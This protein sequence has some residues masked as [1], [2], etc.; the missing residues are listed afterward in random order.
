MAWHNH[1]I[2]TL[3][4]A[5]KFGGKSIQECYLGSDIF[6]RK[7]TKI[8][9]NKVQQLE[10][11][12]GVAWKIKELLNFKIPKNQLKDLKGTTSCPSYT[13]CIYAALDETDRDGILNIG[14][15]SNTVRLEFRYPQTEFFSKDEIENKYGINVGFQTDWF[16]IDLR[17]ILRKKGTVIH[18]PATELCYEL[19][20]SYFEE[21][22]EILTGYTESITN[23]LNEGG[24][25]SPSGESKAEVILFR[26]LHYL[27]EEKKSTKNWLTQGSRPILNPNTGNKLELDIQMDI[28]RDNKPVKIAIEIQGRHHYPK[29]YKKEPQKWE[30][31]ENKHQTK[32]KWCL[33]KQIM[34]VWLDWQAFNDV[35]I[36]D[37]TR[38]RKTESR[39]SLVT[40]MIEKIITCYKTGNLYVEVFAENNTLTFS[41]K[42]RPSIFTG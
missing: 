25:F 6:D 24:R 17:H 27:Y 5:K 36:K 19:D 29:E 16:T 7:L 13:A 1:N 9:D 15:Q 42:S 12:I 30:S 33:Q 11:F 21:I 18:L 28:I 3:E 8:D 31:V 40:N 23:F 20:D 4:D 32:I 34:F 22:T 35:V 39:R 41:S 10:N 26:D 2:T 38:P 14:I 37:G